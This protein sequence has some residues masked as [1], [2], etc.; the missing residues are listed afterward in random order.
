MRREIDGADE[1]WTFQGGD[2]WSELD[3][4]FRVPAA[5]W[6]AEWHRLIRAAH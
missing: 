5:L 4:G 1:V 3:V 6:V 2:E